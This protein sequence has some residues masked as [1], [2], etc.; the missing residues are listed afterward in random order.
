M[1]DRV[2]RRCAPAVLGLSLVAAAC[3]GGEAAESTTPATTAPATTTS[4]TTTVSTPEPLAEGE[5]TTSTTT[6][7]TTTEPPRIWDDIERLDILL[8]G[9]DAG[10]G[11]TG[12][13][14]DTVI[15]LSI[16]PATADA[17]MVSVPRNLTEAPLPDGM[18]LWSCDCFPDILT[19]LWA[20]A[21]WFPDAF[22]GPQDPPVNALKASIGL[23]FDVEVDYYALVD[24]AGFVGLFDALGGVLIDV[25]ERI[26]DPSYPHEDG[27]FE[28][29]AIEEGEQ[30]LDGHHALAYA[31]IRHNSGD[32][33]RMH[34][35]RCLLGSL[36][37]ATEP[38]DLISG[39]L[40]AAI[41]EYVETDIP[42]EALD[43]LV[44]LFSR[45]ELDRVATLR[46]T[47]HNYGTTGHQGYQIYDLERIQ[48]DARILMNDPTARLDTQDGDGWEDTCRRSFD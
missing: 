47:S 22:P 3:S 1:R 25:P 12:T 37:A 31:R 10:V 38:G 46:I 8:M 5:T 20:N 11:R 7:T 36:F 32:F 41:T 26:S 42:T 27:S 23:I 28:P 9:S 29:I 2:I 14:T 16:D 24:L 4:T 33:A 39:G 48:T 15:L 6:T 35:Q 21:E 44:D 45:M 40:A 13:R 34:R 43:D 30:T 18:G 17:A 19:H